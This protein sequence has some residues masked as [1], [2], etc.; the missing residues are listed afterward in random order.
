MDDAYAAT[1]GYGPQSSAVS[2]IRP[3]STLPPKSSRWFDLLGRIFPIGPEA[4][5]T[6]LE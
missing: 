6:E 1:R 5:K 3:R 2:R 4:D